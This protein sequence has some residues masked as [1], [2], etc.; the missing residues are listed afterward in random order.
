M[1]EDIQPALIGLGKSLRGHDIG[2]IRF[3][4]SVHGFRRVFV[5]HLNEFIPLFGRTGAKV[6]A[7]FFDIGF[8]HYTMPWSWPGAPPAPVPIGGAPMGGAP[9]PPPMGGG[10]GVGNGVALS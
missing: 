8:F 9:I 7:N 6:A 1:R 10:G 5:K 3:G 2:S 4:H